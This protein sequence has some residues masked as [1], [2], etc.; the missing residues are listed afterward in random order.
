M[1]LYLPVLVVHA[2]YAK[3]MSKS[4]DSRDKSDHPLSLTRN[5]V[6]L[7]EQLA[8]AVLGVPCE[9][10]QR[11]STTVD[12]VPFT[13]FLPVSD[14]LLV[15]KPAQWI[16][17]NVFDEKNRCWLPG[18]RTPNGVRALLREMPDFPPFIWAAAAK[19]SRFSGLAQPRAGDFAWSYNMR[20]SAPGCTTAFRV[21]SFEFGSEEIYV[22]FDDNIAGCVHPTG[23][24]FGQ[25]RGPTRRAAIASH[26]RPVRMIASALQNASVEEKLFGSSGSIPTKQAAKKISAAALNRGRRDSDLKT[27]L[28]L[29]Q[30][31]QQQKDKSS[32]V[33]TGSL[34]CIICTPKLLSFSLYNEGLQH[35]VTLCLMGL[36]VASIRIVGTVANLPG[37]VFADYTGGLVQKH[38]GSDAK[39]DVDLDVLNFIASIPS[40]AKNAPLPFFE[41]VT[42]D[43]SGV[44]LLAALEAF[45]ASCVR[46]LGRKL[47]FDCTVDC[48]L[49]LLQPLCQFLND[50]TPKEYKQRRWAEL[51]NSTPTLGKRVFSSS[52]V[53]DV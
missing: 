52:H 36:F 53:T 7:D 25:V 44:E 49:N 37:G 45:Q 41:H 31:E 26:Q 50:E 33:V 2:Q 4:A 30:R 21:C 10:W 27:S 23:A 51:E 12:G 32:V 28:E 15:R 5:A 47:K 18:Q 40:T 17:E 29:N 16:T 38:L 42:T 39:G 22:F 14:V 20:C 34:H 35:V 48:A 1:F 3:S 9:E 8:E 13:V 46:V 43:T 6:L 11:Y 19:G 24:R